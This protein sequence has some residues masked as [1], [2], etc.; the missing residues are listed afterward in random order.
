MR[1]N[2]I[3]L[4]L[5]PWFSKEAYHGRFPVL[6]RKPLRSIC[7]VSAVLGAP[8]GL[9][10]KHVQAAVSPRARQPKP[11]DSTAISRNNATPSN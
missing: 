11:A 5:L 6:Q 1:Q 2:D 9:S 10:V 8:V 3:L 7:A 4:I